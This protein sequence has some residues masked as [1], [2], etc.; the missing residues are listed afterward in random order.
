MFLSCN[1]TLTIPHQLRHLRHSQLP[2]CCTDTSNE[3]GRKGSNIYELNQWL[4]EFGLGKP[5]S[6]LGGLSAAE[7]WELQ[8]AGYR[9]ALGVAIPPGHS[10]LQ[11]PEGCCS[12]QVSLS[13]A[14][15][16]PDWD[17]LRVQDFPGITLVILKYLEISQIYQRYLCLSRDIPGRYFSTEDI[18]SAHISCWFLYGNQIQSILG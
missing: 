16:K 5:P 12:C 9:M 11:G 10:E 7:T 15:M 4:W 6:R 14:G 3:S 1:S 8:I 17:S 18:L 13:G 2:H